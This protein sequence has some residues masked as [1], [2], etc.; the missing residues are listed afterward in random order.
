[1]KK[2]KIVLFIIGIL[3]LTTQT[4]RHIYVRIHYD[5]PSVL[6]KYEDEEIDVEIK[7]SSSLDTLLIQF[8]NAYHAV[9]DFE[10]DKTKEELKKYFKYKDE[11]YLTKSKYKAAI[12]DWESKREKNH[13]LIVFWLVGLFFIILGLLLYS[14]KL[15]WLG[16]SFIISGFL[17]MIWW[18]SPS[19]Y[20][21]GAHVE[22]LR[23]LNTKIVFS[24]ITLLILIGIW[25]LD[26]K[27]TT[28]Q[29]SIKGTD[30]H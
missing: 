1:M 16:I 4:T 24:I 15:D 23:L 18:S 30:C 11:P 19:F 13:E 2:L 3:I 29:Q 25:F 22:F 12:I 14:K 7:H 28:P 17:E 21:G 26:K 9:I 6:D 27:L 10:K 5:K 8:D 20:T